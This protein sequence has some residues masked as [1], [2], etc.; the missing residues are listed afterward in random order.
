[1]T[2]NIISGSSHELGQ[3]SYRPH[4]EA[5]IPVDNDD[6]RKLTLSLPINQES[7]LHVIK[8]QST[9]WDTQ[10][11][12]NPI[13]Y[14]SKESTTET[15]GAHHSNKRVHLLV[16]SVREERVHALYATTLYTTV[17]VALLVCCM[18]WIR[19]GNIRYITLHLHPETRENTNPLHKHHTEQHDSWATPRMGGYCGKSQILRSR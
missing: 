4:T 9:N 7:Q 10:K 16:F 3:P 18:Q 8:Y 6:S 15:D 5:E 11:P 14:Q 2:D 12:F 17:P 13:T 1:M 19:A